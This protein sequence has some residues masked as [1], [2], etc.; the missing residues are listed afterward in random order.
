MVPSLVGLHLDT[1]SII[2]ISVTMFT[3]RIIIIFIII[4]ISIITISRHFGFQCV[5]HG[6]SQ[7]LRAGMGKPAAPAA[8]VGASK[9][10][11]LRGMIM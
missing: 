6:Q 10:D 8:G 9:S 5:S 7:H 11:K 4:A 3:I 2:I 1:F